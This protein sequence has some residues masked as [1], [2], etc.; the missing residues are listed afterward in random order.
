[1][2]M[3]LDFKRDQLPD[4]MLWGQAAGAA[5]ALCVKNN[6]SPREM[7]QDVSELQAVL[8]SHGAILDGT[9]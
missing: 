8:K 5:A 7:E 4:N 9:K 6:I 3:S 1:M 2:S